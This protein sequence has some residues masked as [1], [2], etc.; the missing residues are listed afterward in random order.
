MTE[1]K[2][3]KNQS[4]RNNEYYGIQ[5]Q[6]DQLYAKS[7]SGENFNSL[8]S[9]IESK[10]NIMLAYRNIKSNKGSLTPA[11]DKQT[12]KDIE[13]LSQDQL[14]MRMRKE[15]KHYQPRLVRRR[16][17]P[18]PNG[19]TRPLGIPNIWDRM[20]QQCILQALEPICEAKFSENSL[21]FRPNRSA[22]QAIAKS[23]YY[24]NQTKL[25]YV[26]DVDIKGFFDEVNHVKLMRQ[27]WTL[28]IH[29]KR[30]LVII[31]KML[32]APILMP[33]GEIVLPT[34]GTPQGG[35]LS[36]LLANVN[37]NE[38]DHWIEGQWA[39]RDFPNISPQ[40]NPNG[41]RRYSNELRFM[42]KNLKLKQMYIVR[43]ADDFKIFTNNR[44][45]AEKI[46]KASQMWLSERLKLPIS[47]EKSK[48]TNL[49]KEYSEFL[50]FKLKARKKGNQ[51]IADTHISDKA[52]KNLKLKLKEQVKI[53]QRTRTGIQTISGINKYNSMVIGL[54]NYYGIA[55]QINPDLNR[56]ARDID[57]M[58]YN[59][60]EKASAKKNQGENPNGYSRKGSYKGNDT[61]ILNYT[62]RNL[63][64]MR[65]YMKRPILPIGAVNAR[66]P[67]QKKNA[68]NKYT[69]EGRKLIHKNLAITDT[70]LQ[71]LRNAPLGTNRM[72]T[73]AMSDN[74]IALYIAQKGKC[75]ISGREILYNHH[76]HHRKLWS[77][78]H[79]DSYKNLI[80]IHEDVHKLIHA[81]VQETINHYMA[82]LNLDKT[83][84]DKLNK[85]RTLVGNPTLNQI[86]LNGK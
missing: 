30:L 28:G 16:D 82:R 85:L 80:L 8:M 65:Y 79:D 52:L 48:V 49:K 68:I 9:L 25:H 74:R 17:I 35:I 47:A 67:M 13:K 10:E 59:R 46:F 6:F 55:N 64:S 38:F 20:V 58:M 71:I 40:F 76:L 39:K 75:P 57:I 23:T 61:G 12:I 33:N 66:N 2:T 86:T 84:L 63:K 1:Q 44:S 3:E 60:F 32:K 69:E 5:R 81:T 53:I 22:E 11:A 73:V 51:R 56:V 72:N 15:F 27:L 54:H 43:Y 4:L 70:E 77:E 24:I 50:G 34:K 19:K 18:K 31:R 7:Q 37:L 42:K 78:K 29:D 26:V 62:K 21:G 14:L 36:P 83:H 41:S 45:N